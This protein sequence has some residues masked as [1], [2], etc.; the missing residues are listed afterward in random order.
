MACPVSSP[1]HALHLPQQMAA[2]T[3]LARHF[4]DQRTGKNRRYRMEDAALGAFAVFFTQCP[5]FLAHQSAMVEAQGKSNAQT[6]FGMHE[7]PSDN[8]I[9]NLLDPVAPHHVFPVFAQTFDALRD[10]GHLESFRMAHGPLLIALDGT[11]YHQS[12][13]VHC[14]QCTVTQ[15]KN[16]EI[17]YAHTVVTPVVVSPEHNR[18]IPLEPEFVVPQDGHAKQD[19]ES[20]AAHRWITA[21]AERYRNLNVTLLGDDL[22]SRQP[23]CEHML[24][25]GFHFILVCKP[26][27]HTTLYAHLEDRDGTGG[28]QT[29]CV[30]RRQ[31]KQT[32]IDTYRFA[33][34][35]PLRA[36]EGALAVNWCE[37]RTT[38]AEGKTM[39]HNAFATTHAIDQSQVADIVKAGRARWRIENG[40]NNTLKTKG[41]HLTH[42]FGHSK[43]H[44]S[45]L[46]ATF[47]LLAFL[48]HTV[49]ELTNEAYRSLRARLPTRQIFFEHVRV[50]THYHCF[51]SF[52]AMLDF[53]RDGLNRTRRDSG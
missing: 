3:E 17:S 41:Y 36:G 23:L 11:S 52:A 27:S 30:T 50:L 51:E 18:V 31:G 2:F 10:A 37:L 6:L 39:Y 33:L 20:A 45:A 40:N 28:V 46:L 38:D 43:Q 9:R 47:N 4:P 5:S 13:T 12:H 35:L 19:C 44:L 29:F 26:T 53:M 21:H 1:E 16:G 25:A 7:I 49:Q 14:Q 22:Y 24:N 32:V 8:Q 48:L 34:S 42:N 15:H